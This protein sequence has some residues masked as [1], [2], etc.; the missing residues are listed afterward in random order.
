MIEFIGELAQFGFTVLDLNLCEMM[1][2][3]SALLTDGYLD[4]VGELKNLRK[5][6]NLIYNQIHAPY[7]HHLFEIESSVKENLKWQIKRSIEIASMLEIPYVVLHAATD[8]KNYSNSLKANIE[9]LEPLVEYAT[10]LNTSLA[11]ENLAYDKNK[12]REYTSDID[13]LVALIDAFK[14]PNIVACYDFGHA[15]MIS[16]NHKENIH[17]LGSHL[18]TLHVADNNGLTDEHL[19]PF[20]GNVDWHE[21][22]K[23]L[24]DIDYQGDFTYEIMFFSQNLPKEVQPQFLNYAYAVASYLVDFFNLKQQEGH[25]THSEF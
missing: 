21:C 15:N 2:P 18:K 25:K 9:W 5:K 24:S 7:V 19:L 20:H 10:N 14:S 1:N 12:R 13:N 3:S 17:K 8:N 6:H 16:S 22:M 4:Y 11:L 23:A